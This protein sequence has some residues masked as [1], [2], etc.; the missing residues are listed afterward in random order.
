MTSRPIPQ[1][2]LG[3]SGISTK[4]VRW[5]E[6]IPWYELPS[7]GQWNQIRFFGPVTP[8]A[9][10]WVESSRGRAT[11]FPVLCLNFDT[12]TGSYSKAG[13]C[14]ICD[15][16]DPKN[17]EVEAIKA[18][19][20]RM[21]GYA[22]AI[23][24]KMQADPT[25]TPWRPIRLPMSIIINLQSL[26]SM[27]THVIDG[28]TYHAD[29]SD[30]YYGMDV[31]ILYNSAASTPQ[32]KYQV[33]RGNH[34]PLTEVETKYMSQLYDWPRL[35][36]YPSISEVKESLQS[37]GYYQHL[38]GHAAPNIMDTLPAMNQNVQR[39]S[40]IQA[41]QSQIQQPFMAPPP[42]QAA[43]PPAP[44]YQAPM[45]P[46]YQAPMAPP[47]PAYQAPAYTA[48][49]H[50]EPE[51]APMAPPPPQAY[52]QPQMPTMP[53]PPM[54]MGTTGFTPSQPIMTM[55]PP[56]PAYQAP[57]APAYQAPAAPITAAPAATGKLFS[58]PGVEGGLSA[59]AFQGVISEFSGK[60]T[61][62][63]PLKMCDKDDLSGMQVLACYGNYV[64]DGDC[65]KCPIRK[66]CLRM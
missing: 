51:V 52:A 7:D 10:H 21:S 29:V 27:N 63:L 40:G 41:P 24:R 19:S 8:I 17:S 36:V 9:S 61:R 65:M 26:K 48:P 62:G 49:Q 31:Y 2:N 64:A 22:H 12:A 11:R 35:I 56:A 34:S 45:A 43:V 54:A 50:A 14:P 13:G 37:N 57:M 60:L 20:P 38:S 58:Y 42:P 23:I 33:Q 5:D 25:A 6:K 16:F 39:I 15:E 30:P 1:S 28:I 3:F 44:A 46:A 66:Q 59:E 47:A 18:L 55:A 4:R 53:P 32:Q